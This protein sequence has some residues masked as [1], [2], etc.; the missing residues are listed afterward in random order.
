MEQVTLNGTTFTFL[1][2]LVDVLVT[3]ESVRDGARH[4]GVEGA[5][6][7]TRLVGH[8]PPSPSH[9]SFPVF[10]QYSMS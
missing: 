8:P 9:L 1:P 7:A 4:E 2:Q 3:L 10:N 5:Q 6:E